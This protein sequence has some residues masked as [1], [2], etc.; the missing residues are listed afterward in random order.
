MLY[1][2]ITHVASTASSWAQ[3]PGQG[4]RVAWAGANKG[5]LQAVKTT[6]PQRAG[7]LARQGRACIRYSQSPPGFGRRVLHVPHA[8]CVIF[9]SN[10]LVLGP[11][12][13][14]CRARARSLVPILSHPISLQRPPRKA[15]DCALPPAWLLCLTPGPPSIHA[16][17][18]VCPPSTQTLP[19]TRRRLPV[20]AMWCL[21]Y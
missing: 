18:P 4:R 5:I 20:S 8:R 12:L 6:G 2:R 13:S 14:S 19:L 9:C 10:A 21:C 3:Q 7:L 11:P 17:C 1:L 16:S 15:H